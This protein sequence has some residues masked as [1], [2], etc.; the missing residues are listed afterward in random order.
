MLYMEEFCYLVSMFLFIPIL[1]TL[2]DNFSCTE[3]VTLDG[4]DL[5][6]LHRDCR[7]ECGSS[8]HVGLMVVA[9]VALGCF[10]PLATYQRIKMHIS[11]NTTQ[12]HQSPWFVFGRTGM[13]VVLIVMDKLFVNHVVAHAIFIVTF[14]TIC[15]LIIGMNG[16]AF[17]FYG[18]HVFQVSLLVLVIWEIWITLVSEVILSNT[19]TT[20]MV[21]LAAGWT[22]II[23]VAKLSQEGKP[24]YLYY[25][26]YKVSPL[27]ILAR[28]YF[29]PGAKITQEGLEAAKNSVIYHHFYKQATTVVP[30]F[31]PSNGGKKDFSIFNESARVEDLDESPQIKHI[32][33][34]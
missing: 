10:T 22:A 33:G 21:M 26:H 11:V 28:D 14:L 19:S 7:V 3:K 2:I 8:E 29:R 17:N 16:T 9:G 27:S 30:H 6:Y 4:E 18:V 13:I 34:G 32:H 12:I 24:V 15:T 23:G 31:T 1:S 25:S 5:Y 20:W